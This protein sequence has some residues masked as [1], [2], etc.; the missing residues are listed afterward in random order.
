MDR[1]TKQ[2]LDRYITQNPD[3]EEE[4]DQIDIYWEDLT[5]EAQKQIRETFDLEEADMSAL[6]NGM[7]VATLH[8]PDEDGGQ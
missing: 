2:A 4:I 7:P 3:I 1:H 5:H 6:Y 8:R